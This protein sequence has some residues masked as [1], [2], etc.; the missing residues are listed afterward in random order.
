MNYILELLHK[1][2]KSEFEGGGYKCLAIF[3]LSTG[4]VMPENQR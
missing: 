4:Q 3:I 2:G 1:S